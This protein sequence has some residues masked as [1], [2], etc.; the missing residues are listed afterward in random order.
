MNP[1]FIDEMSW[2]MA[3]VYGAVTDQIL[4]NLAHHFPYYQAGIDVPHSAFEYQAR[5][6]AQMGQVNRETIQIIRKNLAIADDAL[7]GA[8][9]QSIIDAVNK[10]EK[11][12]VKGVMKGIFAPPTVP[13]PAANQTRAFKLYYKQAADKLNLVNTVMLESTQQAYK[14]T[15]ADIVNR[16]QATQTALDVGAGEVV[17]G[18]SSWNEAVRHSIN[19]MKDNGITGFIDH[20][21]RRWSAEAYTAMDIRTTMANTARAATWETNENFG[22]DLYLVSYHSGARPLCY[23]WQNKVIS[24]T[25]NAR[26]TVDLDGNPVHVY[27]QDETTYGQ[28]AGLFGVNCKHY[29]SPFIPGVSVIRGQPQSPAE[30]KET[31]EQSQEQRRLERK[32]RE[33]KRDV[34]MAKAQGA[35][36]E[37][38]KT[39]QNRARQTSQDIDEFCRETG[40]ARHRDREGVYTQRTFPNPL[41]YDPKT[42][43][44][45]QKELIDGFF[46]HGGSQQGFSFGTLVPNVPLVPNTPPEA[47][48]VNVASQ[49]TQTAPQAPTMTYGEPFNG[50]YSKATQ[51]RFDAAKKA[52]DNAP[53]NIKAAWSKAAP[54]MQ[55]PQFNTIPR[56][57]AYYD[58]SVNE[59]H[60]KTINKAFGVS[61][62]QQENSVFFHEYGHNVDNILGGNNKTPFLNYSVRYKRGAFGR[63]IEKDC[64]AAL[65]QFHSQSGLKVD[66][67]DKSVGQAFAK[68]VKDHYTIYQRGD[69]SDIFEKY[70]VNNYGIEYPFNVGHG[71]NYATTYG[72]TECEAFAEMF[73]ATVTNSDSL[74]V[75]KQ[76]L[77][78]A[79]KV[80]E[81]MLGAVK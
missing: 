10:A 63:A 55:Q 31:Y 61:S 64:A 56:H 77:P 39:L 42:F 52:L 16:V 45:E 53:D 12:L 44:R 38:I 23:D 17:A 26:D 70:M 3:E 9:E 5:M 15:V 6:L 66:I 37:E 4:I 74:P 28:A 76:F 36:E 68:W 47:P 65:Q 30:N 46:K 43:E 21:G 40:R 24:S 49:A 22:N 1:A 60:F 13:I 59:V 25:N 67:T 2:E 58:P 72:S 79:Y 34:M 51:K 32:L 48:V 33:Q 19:R 78:K 71:K 18:V 8:L 80:F 14:L 35:S 69:I 57:D 11:P 81:E 27:A 20:A 41:T 54:D 7:S 50:S 62:Y 29:P 73:A 75:I